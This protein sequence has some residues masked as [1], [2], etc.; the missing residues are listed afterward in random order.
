MELVRLF[1]CSVKGCV[2]VVN[3][4]DVTALLNEPEREPPIPDT[5]IGVDKRFE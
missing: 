3:I 1:D 4:S 5:A 2:E